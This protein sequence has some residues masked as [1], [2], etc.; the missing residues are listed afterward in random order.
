M[1]IA[2]VC[3]FIPP[4]SPLDLEAAAR[5]NTFYMVSSRVNMVPELLSENLA[6]LHPSVDRLAFSVV[7]EMDDDATI[8]STRFAKSVIKSQAAVT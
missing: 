8:L 6:S 3:H 2:D 4:G 7:W 5:G 1:H